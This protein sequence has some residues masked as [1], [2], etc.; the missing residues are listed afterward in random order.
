M[1]VIERVLREIDGGKVL[2]VATQ[3]GHFVQILM[4]NLKSYTEI[5]GIDINKKAIET[6]WDNVSRENVRFLVMDAEQLDF[7][8]EHFDTVTISA[9]LH[10]LADI[11]R[12][13]VEMMRVLKTGGRFILVEMHEDARTKAARTFVSL[14][15]WV[16]EVD[17]ALGYL[18]KKTLAR[19]EFVNYVTALGLTQLGYYDYSDKDSD[20]KDEARIEQLESLIARTIQRAEN[21]K[22][23]LP[24][25]RRGEEL[26]QRLH[27]VGAQ[28]EPILM[29]VGK[30]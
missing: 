26:R 20:P 14:H 22:N 16:A 7:E 25:K 6:A 24:L 5:V 27:A 10:H 30:K 19:Q 4:E 1:E 18:H 28:R 29:V 15:Q 2:D 23:F 21:A 12:A 9:S 13:L 3:E 17:S 11:R 8:N